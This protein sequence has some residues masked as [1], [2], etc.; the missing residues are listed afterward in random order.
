MISKKCAVGGITRMG[1]ILRSTIFRVLLPI[2]VS[3]IRALPAERSRVLEMFREFR[4][5]F[6]F[7]GTYDLH[8]TV[9]T[10]VHDKNIDMLITIPRNHSFFG[11]LFKTSNTKKLILESNIPILAAQEKMWRNANV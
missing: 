8:E 5:E 10:F 11:S 4:P 3:S 7:I 1:Q 9:Q 2:E 6:Y